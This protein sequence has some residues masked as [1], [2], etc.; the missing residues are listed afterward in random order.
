M[1]RRNLT[2]M[3][4]KRGSTLQQFFED[5][6]EPIPEIGCWM[7]MGKINKASSAGYGDIRQK[8]GSK[9]L[10]AHRV[11]YELYKGPIPPGMLVCHKCDNRWCVNPDHLFLGTIDDNNKDKTA[12]GRNVSWMQR[13]EASHTSKLTEDD[14][15]AIRKDH[16]KTAVIAAEYGVNKSTIERVRNYK[17]WTHVQD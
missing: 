4:C 12:K 17:Y 16:R 5:R 11:S 8:R 14:V 2:E 10:K 7:W 13:G 3:G 9:T 1:T 6:Y 15:R